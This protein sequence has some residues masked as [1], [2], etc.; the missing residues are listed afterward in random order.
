MIGRPGR[1]DGG[2]ERI[3][4]HVDTL[5]LEGLDVAEPA[6]VQS[7][8]QAELG[9]LVAT[10]GLPDRSRARAPGADLAGGTLA[11]TDLG[12]PERLG[13][14]VARHVYAELVK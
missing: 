8:F 4:V 12:T 14:A 10:D 9:R 6:R 5:G 11:D 7:A 13:Q 1:S 3:E 2:G